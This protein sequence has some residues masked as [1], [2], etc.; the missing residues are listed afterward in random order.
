MIN[1][2]M[3]CTL[4]CFYV[5]FL[6]TDVYFVMVNKKGR[7]LWIGTQLDRDVDWQSNTDLHKENHKHRLLLYM[8][9]PKTGIQNVNVDIEF[10]NFENKEIDNFMLKHN[11]NKEIF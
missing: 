11:I 7:S 10:K 3:V 6:Y 2:S 1:K 5:D 4:L 8:K 9:G